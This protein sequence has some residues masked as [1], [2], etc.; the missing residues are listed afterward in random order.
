MS[1]KIISL[2]IEGKR[3]LDQVV[4]FLSGEEA[5][6][7]CLQ[8][9]FE[10]DLPKL[11]DQFYSNHLFLPIWRTGQHFNLEIKE[12]YLPGDKL[13]G[14]ALLSRQ[15]LTRLLAVRLDPNLPEAPQNTGPGT[16]NPALLVAKADN[17]TIATTHFTWTPKGETNERQRQHLNTL[18]SLLKP[19]PELIFIGDFNT[20]RGD[21]IH[22][23]LASRF[24]D[25]PPE[26]IDTTLDPKLHYANLNEPGKLKLVVDHLFTTPGFTAKVEI[27]DGLSDHCAIVAELDR[28]A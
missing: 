24:V 1:L 19:Y 3:H 15:P 18:L 6:V 14:I 23:T 17:F 2:N 25:H 21:E 7:V 13:F 28:Q 12:G 9:V 20:P 22:A 27:K 16:W 5:D 11:K 4:P 10:E 8:E 26:D